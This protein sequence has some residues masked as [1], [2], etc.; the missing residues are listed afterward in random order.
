[1]TKEKIE[2]SSDLEIT[3]KII[4]NILDDINTWYRAALYI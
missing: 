3:Y 4:E 1:M 2:K